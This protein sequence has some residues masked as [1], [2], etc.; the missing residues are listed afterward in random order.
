[1]AGSSEVTHL[2]FPLSRRLMRQFGMVVEAFLLAVFDT[3]QNLHPGC[4][5]ALQFVSDQNAWSEL[6]ALRSLRK[7]LLAACRSRRFCLRT[8]SV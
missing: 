7:N 6:Q 1:M 3:R 5:I 4:S 8:S 2:P